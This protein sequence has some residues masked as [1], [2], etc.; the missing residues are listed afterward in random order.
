MITRRT[1]ESGGNETPK[2]LGPTLADGERKTLTT[3]GILSMAVAPSFVPVTASR[4]RHMKRCCQRKAGYA[5]LVA[6]S[7]MG[8]ASRSI[9]V[10]HRGE[11]VV[12]SA[13][14]A[15]AP[16]ESSKTDQD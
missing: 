10:T 5:L 4:W 8:F 15:I 3:R 16:W 1:K 2:K 14:S 6:L 9:I 7:R 12:Y 11:F 13:L